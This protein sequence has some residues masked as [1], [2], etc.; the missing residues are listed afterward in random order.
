MLSTSDRSHGRALNRYAVEV[1]APTGHSWT[2]LPE[3][4]EANGSS[5]N[6][7]IWVLPLRWLKWISLSP[8][9]P[10]AKRVQ[11]SH[12]MQR[13]RSRYT[14]SLIGIGFSKWRFSSKNRDS[15]GP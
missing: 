4:Y 7:E 3:K 9:T 13:S 15:P 2:V 6:V 12:R 8:A 1:R 10:S 11:R 14:R 5:G